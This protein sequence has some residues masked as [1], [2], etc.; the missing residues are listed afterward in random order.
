VDDPAIVGVLERLG[1]LPGN[2][3]RVVERQRAADLRLQT[4][5]S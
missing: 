2:A 5:G 3:E 1:E 4:S